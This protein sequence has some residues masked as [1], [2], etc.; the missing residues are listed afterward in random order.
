M[1]S[2]LVGGLEVSRAGSQSSRGSL[3]QLRSL[4]MFG[5]KLVEEEM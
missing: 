3:D 5:G 4:Q 2:G 1:V